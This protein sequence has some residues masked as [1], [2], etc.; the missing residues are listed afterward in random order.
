[1]ISAIV[2]M[3]FS[4]FNARVARYKVGYFESTLG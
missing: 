3:S 1:L 4:A 2:R